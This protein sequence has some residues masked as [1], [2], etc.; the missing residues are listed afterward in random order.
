MQQALQI[1]TQVDQALIN[2]ISALQPLLG[3]RVQM[4]ALDLG[5]SATLSVLPMPEQQPL[6]QTDVQTLTGDEVV[7]HF[8]PQTDLGRKLIALRRAYVQGGGKLLSL[9]EV[10]AEVRQCRGGVADD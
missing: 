3:H 8:Q 2:A 6:T 5:Q 4:I 7:D 10:N 1:Q 9:D